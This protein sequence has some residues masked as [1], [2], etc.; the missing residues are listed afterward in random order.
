MQLPMFRKAETVPEMMH[1]DATADANNTKKSKQH[2]KT[3]R[4]NLLVPSHISWQTPVH[5]SSHL[6]SQP[7][8][9]TFQGIF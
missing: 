9:A 7:K 1:C 8:R 5:I 2:Q 3:S 6:D 4:G